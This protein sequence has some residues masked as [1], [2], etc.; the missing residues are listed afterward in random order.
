MY[1]KKILLI[2]KTGQLGSDILRNGKD[3]DIFAPTRKAVDLK[4][5]NSVISAIEDFHPHVVINTAAFHNVP[6]CEYEYKKAFQINCIAVGKMAQACQETGSLFVTIST[7]YVFDGSNN[8]PYTEDA[9]PRPL[10]I[11]G[12]SKLAGEFA[13]LSAAPDKAIIIRT[14][15]LYGLSGASSKGENFVDKRI[16]DAENNDRVEVSCE[17]I[18]CPTYTDDLSIAIL[19]L[20]KHPGINPGIYHL[21]NEGSCSWYDFTKTIYEIMKIDIDLQPINRNGQ[22]AGFRRPLYSV[23]ANKKAKAMGIT[24]PH[25]RSALKRY[26]KIKYGVR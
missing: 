9:S 17:Q 16:K 6:L 7:D 4:S 14:C 15:G 18:V 8:E 2:G 25:W 3:F 20:L 10:Q 21:V 1:P 11:Y 23:L 22:G 13:A 24:L 5:E 19:E 26:L 12:I